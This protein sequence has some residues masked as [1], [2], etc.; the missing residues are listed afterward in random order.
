[1]YFENKV[2]FYWNWEKYPKVLTEIKQKHE[3][4]QDIC[5]HPRKTKQWF[6]HVYSLSLACPLF[7]KKDYMDWWVMTQRILEAISWWT[8]VIWLKDSKFI[9]EIVQEE[10]IAD[11]SSSLYLIVLKLQSQNREERT[12]TYLKQFDY[13]E[14]FN[15]K[16]FY[17]KLV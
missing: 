1:M 17:N 6:D 2:H 7:L 5:F 8:I 11:C 9:E 15:I 4:F 13:L 14:A 3:C 12:K 10:M 16:S